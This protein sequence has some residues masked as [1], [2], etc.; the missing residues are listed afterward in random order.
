MRGRLKGFAGPLVL[1]VVAGLAIRVAYI[2]LLGERVGGIGDYFFYDTSANLLAEGKGFIDPFSLATGPARP[3]AEHPPL[4]SM[5]LS[6]TSWLGGTGFTSHKLTGAVVGAAAIVPIGLLGRRVAGDRAGLIAAALAAV[7][8]TFIASDGS[9]MSE[10]LYGLLVACALVAAYRLYDRADLVSAAA[11]GAFLGLSALTRAEGVLLLGLLA[12]PLCWRLPTDV[13]AR[14]VRFGVVVAAAVVVIA[15][16]TARNWI[17]FDRPVLISINDAAVLAGANC[18]QTYHGR[19]IGLWRVDCAS[20]KKGASQPEQADL[21]REKG[22]DYASEH[23]GRLPAVV[24][25]RV[26][27]VWDFWAPYD[28]TL[29]EGRQRDVQ[30]AGTAMYFLLLALGAYGVVLLRRRDQPLLILAAPVVVVTLSAMLGYGLPRFRQAAE[31]VIVVLAAAA[32]AELATRAQ[33][34]RRQ[35]K[36]SA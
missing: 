25:V 19:D 28:Q 22:L 31:V 29:A 6:V 36:I 21:W 4:W 17:Q 14:V 7:Y 16:W 23:P 2:L 20:R 18:D 12:L 9:L 10:S 15:P 30:V 35:R 11:L 34:R 27:R 33:E 32:L 13:R 26:L 3:T 1:I 24:A 8:P 5:V